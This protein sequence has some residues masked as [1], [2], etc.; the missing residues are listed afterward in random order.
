MSFPQNRFSMFFWPCGHTS[1]QASKQTIYVYWTLLY[2]KFLDPGNP[3]V[4]PYKKIFF[5]K[6]VVLCLKKLIL[7]KFQKTNI[8]FVFLDPDYPSVNPYKKIFFCKKV[9]LCLKKLILKKFQKTNIGFEFLD[10][11]YPLVE[12]FRKESSLAIL[13]YFSTN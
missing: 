5:C 4:N 1:K 7:K 11:D 3:S 6:K 9:V 2:E 13:F 12:L 10:P 8:G